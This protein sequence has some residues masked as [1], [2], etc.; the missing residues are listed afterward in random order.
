MRKWGSIVRTHVP[1]I[2]HPAREREVNN[3]NVAGKY[4]RLY[5]AIIIKQGQGQT[6]TY[7]SR[8][9]SGSSVMIFL[10]VNIH[11]RQVKGCGN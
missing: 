3:G 7:S 2:H 4:S 6:Y 8:E 1:N 9:A 11:P 10:L 5:T